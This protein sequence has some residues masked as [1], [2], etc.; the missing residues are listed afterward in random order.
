MYVCKTEKKRES[1]SNIL[2]KF[3]MYKPYNKSISQQKGGSESFRFMKMSLQLLDVKGRSRLR[4]NS[5]VRQ[6]KKAN[7]GIGSRSYFLLLRKNNF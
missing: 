1:L 4:H 2:L 7:R 6:S 5:L 3:S